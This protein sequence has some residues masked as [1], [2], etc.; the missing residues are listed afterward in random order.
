MSESVRPGCTLETRT[1][2]ARSSSRRASAKARSANFD[3]AYTPPPGPAVNPDPLLIGTTMP[4]AARS[5]GSASRVS[6]ATAKTL[7]A[8]TCSH[9]SRGV[10]AIRVPCSTPALCTRTSSDPGSSGTS[11]APRSPTNGAALGSSAT[12]AATASAERPPTRTWWV[13]PSSS[14]IARPMPRVAP[15]TSAVGRSAA[16]AVSVMRPTLRSGR[17][18]PVPRLPAVDGDAHRAGCAGPAG[19]LLSPSC[20]PRSRGS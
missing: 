2:F 9:T 4:R 3:A 5:A 12:S 17:D 10:S 19:H 8:N 11:P 18:G 13:R 20:A 6:S 14:A 16:G 15:V 1:P 7:V